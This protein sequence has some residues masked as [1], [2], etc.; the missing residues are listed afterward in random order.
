[1]DHGQALVQGLPNQIDT[2]QQGRTNDDPA[3][4]RHPQHP[5]D[6]QRVFRELDWGNFDAVELLETLSQ[7]NRIQALPYY[8]NPLVDAW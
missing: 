2:L 6:V 1:M 3:E 7:Q 5:S 8:T 4:T